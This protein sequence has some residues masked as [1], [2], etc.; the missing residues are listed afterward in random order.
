[1]TILRYWSPGQNASNQ[2]YPRRASGKT[3]G[4]DTASADTED[5]NL[6][7]SDFTRFVLVYHFDRLA[8]AHFHVI[9]SRIGTFVCI[10]CEH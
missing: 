5:F 1:M 8:D 10:I 7:L 6:P 3:G 4:P 2:K 9:A